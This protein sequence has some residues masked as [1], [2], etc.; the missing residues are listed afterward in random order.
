[1]IARSVNNL[2]YIIIHH[3]ATQKDLTVADIR[4]IHKGMGYSDVGYHFLINEQG[5]KMTGR[6]IGYSGAHTLG[7]KKQQ[8]RDARY[9]YVVDT[10]YKGIGISLIGSF[11]NIA[12]PSIMI[13]ETAY[14]IKKLCEKYNIPLT[15]DRIFGH[16]EVDLTLCPGKDTMKLIYEKLKI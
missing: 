15:R 8:H 3:T 4:R 6:P 9:R 2:R 7:E 14:L 13:N 12:P 11:E 16:N 10:N 5:D 1:M